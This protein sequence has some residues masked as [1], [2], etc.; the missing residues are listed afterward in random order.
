MVVYGL[1]R[2]VFSDLVLRS[3]FSFFKVVFSSI[4]VFRVV[5]SWV[6]MSFMRRFSMLI[7]CMVGEFSFGFSVMVITSILCFEVLVSFMV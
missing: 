3:V 2:F 5:L 1:G 6:I 4:R 7:C